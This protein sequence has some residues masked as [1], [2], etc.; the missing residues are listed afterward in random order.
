MMESYLIRESE[1]VEGEVINPFAKSGLVRSPT[2][3]SRVESPQVSE[4]GTP[5]VGSAIEDTQMSGAELTRALTRNRDGLPKLLVVSEQLDELIGYTSGRNNISKDLKKG[6]LR[7]RDSVAQARREYDLLFDR[8]AGREERSTQTDRSST[9]S[10]CKVQPG[11]AAESGKISA[12]TKRPRS[13]DEERPVSGK[14]PRSASNAKPVAKRARGKEPKPRGETAKSG[15]SDQPVQGK[16]NPWITVGKRGRVEREKVLSKTKAKPAR[17]RT[18]G[19]AL[20]LKAEGNSYAEVLRAM[21]SEVRL[22]GLGADVKSIRRTRTG[23][24][25]LELK[26]N[27]VNKGSSYTALAQEVLGEKVRV[28][29]L[30]PEMTIQCKNLDEITTAEELSA[31]LKQQCNVDAPCASIRMR[32]G[33]AGMQ[34]ATIKLPV[35]EAKK[36]TAKGMVEVGWSECP[37]SVC[38]PPEVCFRCFGRG[39]K[40]WAC[41]GPDRSKLCRRCGVEGHF[42]RECKS[43]P[44]CL[45]CT[46]NK[47]HVTGGPKC[48]SISGRNGRK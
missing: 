24:M 12:Q 11:G 29:A 40:S 3:A 34:I 28:R 7:L 23:E 44:K 19:D 39:H 18:K 35:G 14:R 13:M 41:K 25:M 43:A 31:V 4:Y 10:V 48:P 9:E 17:K 21:R 32:R 47:G 36:A 45:I 42:V 30:T 46:T 8:S 33:P 16:V 6:L 1:N 15:S 38:E 22:S 27:A 5:R 2:Q 20:V 26:K 37:L